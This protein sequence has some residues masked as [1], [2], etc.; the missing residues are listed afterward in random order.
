MTEDK[1]V[2]PEFLSEIGFVELNDE[3]TPPGF[4]VPFDSEDQ[5]C[6]IENQ[7]NRNMFCLVLEYMEG[8]KHWDCL[9]Y[10]QENIGCGF[11]EMPD[12]WA[13]LPV[14]RLNDFYSAFM[15]TKLF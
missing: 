5:K 9:L 6:F 7:I 12:R 3:N 15:G 13:G 14:D 1:L 8:P 10:V 4:N 2:T 11:V